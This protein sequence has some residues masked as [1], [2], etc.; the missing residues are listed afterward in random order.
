M[1]TPTRRLIAPFLL[2]AS[3][4]HTVFGQVPGRD[5]VGPA[6]DLYASA[7]YD[8]ALAV[9]NDLRPGD[10]TIAVA[11]RKSIE[12]YRSLCLL[13]LG[14]GSEA[15][16]AIAAV[17][18]ADP[19]YQPGEVEASPRVRSAFSEVRRRLLPEIA[20]NRYSEAKALFDRK[21][22]A[23]A[24]RN[25][26]QVI[27]LLEDPDMGGKLPDLRTLANGFLDLSVAASA[28]PP[29][30]PK[31][32]AA[33]PPPQIVQQPEV[34][35]IFT[36]MDKDVVPPVVIK[37]QMPQLTTAVKQQA[38]DRG[39]VE[40]VID[41]QGRVINVAVRMSVHPMYDADLLLA[42][43][44]WRYQ[45]ATYLGRPVRYRKMIQINLSQ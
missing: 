44:D 41:E 1:A 16:S 19:T 15:E 32:V 7:R 4:A 29:E 38:K 14:R 6:R 9:L 11:D 20:N 22:Y 26:R 36:L 12:Q 23:T 39:V 34:N 35:R 24:A 33:A 3:I 25:F 42:G 13:A 27:G 2:A 8:E 45:P 17:V 18:T 40:V 28:P 37:Q 21:D 30:P 5:V 43:R 31:P 10:A